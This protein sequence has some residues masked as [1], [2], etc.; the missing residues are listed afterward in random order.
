MILR[1]VCVLGGG[2]G[3]FYDGFMYI[4]LFNVKKFSVVFL[5]NREL[6]PR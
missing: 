5:F 4:C 3:V 6:V 1:C 2:G